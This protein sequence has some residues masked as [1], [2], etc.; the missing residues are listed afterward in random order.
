MTISLFARNSSTTNF[1]SSSKIPEHLGR[2][3]LMECND[4]REWCTQQLRIACMNGHGLIKKLSL[5]ICNHSYADP[6]STSRFL[7]RYLC[8][9]ISRAFMALAKY[10]L[11]NS[12]SINLM[13]MLSFFTTTALQRLFTMQTMVPGTAKVIT[14]FIMSLKPNLPEVYNSYL[15]LYSR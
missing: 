13:I 1:F 3:D 9:S 11:R 10:C 4:N 14:F 15:F 7:N 12:N 8:F 6:Q 5:F 2:V